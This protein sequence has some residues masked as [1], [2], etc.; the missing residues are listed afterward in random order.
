MAITNTKRMLDTKTKTRP[1]A[2]TTAKIP[3][4]MR[5][6]DGAPP[7]AETKPGSDIMSPPKQSY[8]KRMRELSPVVRLRKKLASNAKRMAKIVGEAQR[9]SN[10]PELREATASVGSAL[11]ALLAV[12]SAL[13][14]DFKPERERHVGSRKVSVGMKVGL[15]EKLAS[16]YDGVIDAEE[17]TALEVVSLA[18]GLVSVRTASGARIVLPIR[19]V[20]RLASETNADAIQSVASGAGG[21]S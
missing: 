16:K 20:T 18:K 11:T 12:A 21:A 14:D 7:S 4:V 6:P 5:R 8:E 3:A 19:H 15:V 2:E 1:I 17:R 9:W 10:A 13:P